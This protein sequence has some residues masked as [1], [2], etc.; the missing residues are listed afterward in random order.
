MAIG[1]LQILIIAFALFAISRAFLRL[2]DNK[3]TKKEFMFWSVIWIILIIMTLLPG[4][5]ELLSGLFGLK[6]GVDVLIY[7]AIIALFYL[8]FRLYVKLDETRQDITKLVRKIS[9]ENEIIRRKNKKQRR[10]S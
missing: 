8:V 1:F 2:K 7:I 10:N 3:I 6:R 4:I 9:I 5:A